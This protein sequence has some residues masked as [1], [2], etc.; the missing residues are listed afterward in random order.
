GSHSPRCPTIR[1]SPTPGPPTPPTTRPTRPGRTAGPR[2]GYS[3]RHPE[4]PM[5]R[6]QASDFDQELLNLFDKYVHGDIDRRGFLERAGKFAVGGVTAAMLLDALNPR[7]AEAEVV[8][9]DDKRVK[10]ETIEFDSPKGNGKVKGYFAR[11]AAAK[12]K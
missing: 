6:K 1:P 9:K 10:T 3:A 8:A 5:E 4:G 2:A 7:F 11:P 12:G